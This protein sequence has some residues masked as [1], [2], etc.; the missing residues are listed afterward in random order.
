LALEGYFSHFELGDILVILGERLNWSFHYEEYFNVFGR[1]NYFYKVT[2]E[3][4]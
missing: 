3:L 1:N 4:R 2:S